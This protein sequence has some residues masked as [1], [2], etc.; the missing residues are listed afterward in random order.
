MYWKLGIPSHHKRKQVKTQ[1]KINLPLNQ[2]YGL[3]FRSEM[4]P[5]QVQYMGTNPFPITSSSWMNT[6]GGIFWLGTDDQS[7]RCI[8]MLLYYTAKVQVIRQSIGVMCPTNHLWRHLQV[9][10]PLFKFY[11]GLGKLPPHNLLEGAKV[12]LD[13]GGAFFG[14]VSVSI[15]F[16]LAMMATIGLLST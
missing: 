12:L 14:F 11:L 5:T 8:I 3:L 6:L 4:H 13:R 1:V 16:S 15:I 10:P 9:N 7:V 2:A